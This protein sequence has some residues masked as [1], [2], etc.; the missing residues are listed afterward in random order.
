M[1]TRSSADQSGTIVSPTA[2]EN[3]RKSE[4]I[5]GLTPEHKGWQRFEVKPKFW[6]KQRHIFGNS[7]TIVAC[8]MSPDPKTGDAVRI[9]FQK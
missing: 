4:K 3:C 8:R 5:E 6:S 7:R 9:G 1:L 2:N